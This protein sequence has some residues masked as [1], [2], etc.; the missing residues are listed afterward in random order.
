MQCKNCKKGVFQQRPPFPFELK[1]I[2]KT[3]ADTNV[4]QYT[5]DEGLINRIFEL[6]NIVKEYVEK[7]GLLTD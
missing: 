2:K 6:E 5:G 7:H 4:P 3:H 1:D